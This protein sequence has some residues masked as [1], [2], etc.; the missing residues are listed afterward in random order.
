MLKPINLKNGIKLLRFPKPSSNICIIGFVVQTGS[1]IEYNNYPQGISQLV[2][3]IFWRGTYKH[4]STK[5]LNLALENLGG[6]FYSF[7]TQETSQFYLEV[8]DY[9][10]FKAISFLA[11]IIQRSYFDA[12]DIE[13]EK[14]I[15]LD[16]IKEPNDIQDEIDELTLSNLYNNSSLGLPISGFVETVNQITTTEVLDYLSHQYTPQSVNFVIAGNFE[17]KKSLELLDQEFSVWNPKSKKVIKAEAS[18]QLVFDELPKITYRQRGIGQTYLSLAFVMDYG[19]KIIESEDEVEENLENL[20]DKELVTQRLNG[21]ATLM[22]LNTILGQGYSSRL[23]S[24]G[25]E[26]E[27]LFGNIE[28]S[29]HYFLNTSFLEIKGNLENNQFSFGLECILSCLDSVKKTTV[30]INEISKAKSYLRGMLI[31]DQESVLLSTLWQVD[32]YIGSGLIFELK[33][34]LSKIEKVEASSVRSLALDLF[35]PSRLSISTLGPAKET[36]I[37]E[38]LIDKYLS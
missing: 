37:V 11:E 3:K 32:Q 1:V 5:H 12:R 30:S 34:L 8:P 15:I 23:W 20:N 18:E 29:L 13:L 16:K 22:V 10:Q 4:P 26:E 35:I 27:N 36:R 9:N 21:M 25:V 31:R 6:K 19:L 2:E 38:K 24:K 14:K 7:T 17:S 28:S 33:E